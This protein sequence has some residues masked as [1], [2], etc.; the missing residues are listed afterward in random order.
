MFNRLFTPKWEH[1]DPRV[2]CQALEGGDA[3][4]EAVAKAAREDEDPEVRRCAVEHLDDLE[5]LAA[6]AATESV[7]GIREV[8][9]RRQRELLAGPLHAGPPLQVRLEILQRV[10]TPEFSLFLARQAQVAEIR[11]AGLEQVNETTELCTIAVEDPVAAVR[12]A[13]LERIE[14]PQGWETVAREARKKD[15]Q[16]SRLARER[17]DAWQQACSDRDSAEQLCREMEGILA[18]S[19]QAGDAIRI[20]RLDCQWESLESIKSPE[21]T[22]RYHR[23]RKQVA[24]GIERLVALQ[25]VKREICADLEHLLAGQRDNAGSDALSAGDLLDSLEAVIGRWQ[26]QTAEADEDDTLAQRFARLVKQVRREAERLNSDHACAVPLQA[27][28]KQAG[29]LR[30][31]HAK[32]DESR[33]KKLESRWASLDQP[34]SRTVAE[35]LQKDFDNVLRALRDRLDRERRQRMQALDSAKVLLAE[36]ESALQAGELERALSQR[37]RLRHLLKTGRGVDERKRLAMQ[38]QLQGMQPRLEELRQWRHWGGGK[39]RLR[40]CAE[41]EALA[42][43]VLGAEEVA[44]RV[45]N[46]RDAWKRIDHAE[47][48]AGEALWHRFDQACTR[49]Y[50]PY[51]RK[52]RVLAEQRVAH[53]E[54]KQVLCRELDAFERDTDWKQVDWHAADQ[55]VRKTQEHWRRIG[56]V[57]G[58]AHK[59]MEKNYREVLERLES[60]LGKE[61]ERE[62]QRRRALIAAVE[63][64]ATAP[65]SRAAVRAAKEAQAKWKPTVQAA[66]KV[67]QSLWKQFRS[68]CDVVFK[69]S[70]EQRAAAD[71]E[72]QTNFERKTALCVELETLLE[73][74][75]TD[76]RDLAQRFGKL[77]SEWAGIGPIPRKMEHAALA[78]YAALEKRFAQRQQQEEEAAAEL[79][80]QGLRARS[81]LCEC[82]EAEVLESTMGAESHQVLVEETRQAWQA[83]DTLDTHYEKV[84]R[85]RLDLASLALGGD[86]QARQTLLEGV[87]KNLDK[88]LELCLQ[89]E[90]AAGIDTPTEF[91][92]ARM[93]FQ[94]S[95]LADALHHKLEEP[96]ACQDQLWHLQIAWYQAGSVPGDAQ[97]SLDARFGLAIASSGSGNET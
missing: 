44:A 64:L 59:S 36:L 15:K 2:R 54:Q 80:L 8:A 87:P 71:A 11:T 41:I 31:E 97:G 92:G 40:L 20:R 52:R 55:R 61:R 57:P 18:G 81:R 90:I 67:E 42:D 29:A 94:V 95:R 43:T 19:L 6:I 84:L 4:A 69:H 32:L 28:I 21:L 16:V 96:R 7:P 88:R 49:A 13:A 12:R 82:L 83:L 56:P 93:E 38:E 46:A 86:D 27:L 33:I 68:A 3:P 89:M 14:D 85:E 50:E 17:L 47:G 58:K 9:D 37:D 51:Q 76:V 39:A 23:A 63:K 1:A 65:D 45:R 73:D 66:R 72:Q 26:T 34:T 75:D 25:S 22:T 10:R 35:V 48:P 70:R 74:A 77:R 79:K 78:R 53:F 5:L 24:A 60:H 62:L 91:A 30:D